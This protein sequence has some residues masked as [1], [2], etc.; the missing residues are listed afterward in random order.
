MFFS[1]Q[2]K[3][4]FLSY[5]IFSEKYPP[6]HVKNKVIDFAPSNKNNMANSLFRSM[7]N[8]IFGRIKHPLTR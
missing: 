1:K 5:E 8:E 4:S 7:W 2:K 6:R 3:T